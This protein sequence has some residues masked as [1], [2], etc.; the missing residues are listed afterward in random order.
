MM[1]LA[2]PTSVVDL[3]GSHR[4]HA[5][6]TGLHCLQNSPPCLHP[7]ITPLPCCGWLCFPIQSPKSCPK[8]NGFI[9]EALEFH[10]WDWQFAGT[11]GVLHGQ[12]AHHCTIS[13]VLLNMTKCHSISI[14]NWE[15]LSTISLCNDCTLPDIQN[16]FYCLVILL[17]Y[18]FTRHC[19]VWK[20]MVVIHS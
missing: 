12:A 1:S 17:T 19:F 7:I 10:Q 13:T 16:H 14:E 9:L 5:V 20:L 8:W 4:P 18:N 3:H 2:A 15:L 6:I 11:H